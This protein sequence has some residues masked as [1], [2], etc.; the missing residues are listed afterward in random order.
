[1][2]SAE[3]LFE[4]EYP[5]IAERWLVAQARGRLHRHRIRH[6]RPLEPGTVIGELRTIGGRVQLR[7]QF[8]GTFQA[9][10]APE[11]AS[12]HPGQPVAIVL[13]AD[14]ETSTGSFVDRT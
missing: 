9:W 3:V 12:V 5:P 13:P 10:I 6:G 11:G 7:S 8:A 2:A 4:G 1:M 14:D